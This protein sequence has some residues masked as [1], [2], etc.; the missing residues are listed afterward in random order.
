MEISFTHP[1]YLWLLLVLPFLFLIHFFSLKY[2]NR[3]GVS[4]AN[5]EA[6]K[7]VT[8]GRI[9]SYNIPLLVIRTLT[10]FLLV[11]SAAG[12]IIWFKGE[13]SDYNYV[14]ALDA[15]GSMLADDFS[16]NRFEAAKQAAILFVDT[17]K[18][19]AKIGVVSFSGIAFIEQRLTDSKAQLRRAIQGIKMR[20]MHGTAIGDAMKTAE[21]L[22]V[23]EEKSRIIILLT[24]GRE[25]VASDDEMNK[26]LDELKNEKIIVHIIGIG[27]EK[28]GILPGI[29][30]ISTLDED[31]LMNVAN[32]TSG[33]Y[34][35]ADNN[36]ALVNAY[37]NL[38]TSIQALIPIKLQF[39]F[40]TAVF[41]LLFLEWALIN[42]KYRSIP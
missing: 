42:T 35:K 9:I 15:S 4:F 27:T 21:N 32:A 8:G 22:L 40:L 7:R 38:A 26:L 5:F 39:P 24:D 2:I 33:S 34:F 1:I 10:L 6:L 11:F 20:S 17:L 16:P 12:T 41:A 3:K 19:K 29:E 37:S 14:L 31:F 13:S 28:G 23:T 25:N 18:A 30:A 36:Q